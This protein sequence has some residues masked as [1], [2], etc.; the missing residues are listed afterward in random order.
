MTTNTWVGWVPALLQN[1][2]QNQYYQIYQSNQWNTLQNATVST[3]IC[4]SRNPTGTPAPLSYIVNCGAPDVKF[5]DLP[6]SGTIP[7]MDFQENGVFFDVFT[8][9]WA[10]LN[11]RPNI[12]PRITT[13]ISWINKHDGNAQ[14]LMLSES[15]DALDWIYLPGNP[16]SVPAP[17]PPGL[18]KPN[19]SAID[20]ESWWQGCTWDLPIGS[21]PPT[22]PFKSDNTVGTV[23]PSTGLNNK[24]ILNRNAGTTDNYSAGNSTAASAGLP[25]AELTLARPSSNHSGGFVV[26]MTDAH[27]QFLS[28]EIDYRVFY[29]L[30]TPD[31]RNTKIPGKLGASANITAV[32]FSNL[33]ISP[34]DLSK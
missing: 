25:T 19:V 34:D 20:G 9:Q 18:L 5:S 7:S 15:I 10:K 24:L 6:T 30:M 31:S 14:T 2:E 27:T 1:L 12:P 21:S 22:Y 32:P 28:Q 13:D 26:T 8:P 4:P 11:G 3:L 23:Y 29:L 33:S 16:P 17:T